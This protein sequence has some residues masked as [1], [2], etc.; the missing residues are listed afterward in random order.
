ME[1]D[2][3]NRKEL[4][5]TLKRW[6]KKG[7]IYHVSEQDNQLILKK[8]QKK[9]YDFAYSPKKDHMTMDEIVSEIYRIWKIK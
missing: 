3:R 5:K 6:M 8:Q 2:E 1:T 9:V 7:E 4:L